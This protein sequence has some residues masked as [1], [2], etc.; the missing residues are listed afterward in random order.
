M[1]TYVN[2]TFEKSSRVKQK[3]QKLKRTVFVIHFRSLTK[4]LGLPA[5]AVW[6][7]FSHPDLTLSG[8]EWHART[9]MASLYQSLGVEALLS[10]HW[11]G[12]V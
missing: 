11:V 2:I 6:T 12:T 9:M 1:K 3:K 4:D 10:E 8:L 5:Q 7:C